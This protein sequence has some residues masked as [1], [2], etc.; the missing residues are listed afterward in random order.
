VEFFGLPFHS[1]K[2]E[3]G[4]CAFLAGKGSCSLCLQT[5][6]RVANKPGEHPRSIQCAFGLTET[7]VP[8][9]LGD[10]V[11]GFLATGQIFTRPP[12]QRSSGIEFAASLPSAPR[13]KGRQQL[14]KKPEHGAVAMGPSNC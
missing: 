4:F 11:I 1:K 8:V 5:Q 9:R 3:N 12:G 7:T 2:N 6:G 10:R 13:R 14:W